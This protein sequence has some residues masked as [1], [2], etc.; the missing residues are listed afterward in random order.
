MKTFLDERLISSTLSLK[1]A[2]SLTFTNF[3]SFRAGFLSY[4]EKLSNKTTAMIDPSVES[5]IEPQIVY[6]QLQRAANIAN[7][8]RR[9]DFLFA[10]C[11]T[12]DEF[13]IETEARGCY[14]DRSAIGGLNEIEVDIGVIKQNKELIVL[15]HIIITRRSFGSCLKS[16]H[17]SSI[18]SQTRIAA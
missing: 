14:D 15:E 12:F 1:D 4:I 13:V 8:Y 11:A 3:A 16:Y 10:N 5:E 6:E 7:S 2:E 17:E 9:T 18:F